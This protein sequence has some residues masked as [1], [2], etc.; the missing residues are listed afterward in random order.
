ML[1]FV[2]AVFL[3]V[4]F[5]LNHTVFAQSCDP[6]CSR[7]TVWEVLD[8]GCQWTELSCGTQGGT[9]PNCNLTGSHCCYYE[10]SSCVNGTCGLFYFRKCYVGG[11]TET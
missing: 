8:Y 5:S 10:W 11:C 9:H 1:R 7:C 6:S 4:S 2:A 3:T